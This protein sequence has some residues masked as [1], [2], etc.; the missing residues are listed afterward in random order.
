M[1]LVEV[2]VIICKPI[3]NEGFRHCM[4]ILVLETVPKPVILTCSDH[5]LT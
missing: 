3:L 5:V 2:T 1:M 4:Y